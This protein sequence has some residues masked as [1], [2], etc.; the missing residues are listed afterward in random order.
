MSGTEEIINDA[1]EQPVETPNE[2]QVTEETNAEPSFEVEEGAGTGEH[3]PVQADL[4]TVKVDGEEQRV[5]LEELVRGYAHGTAANKRF[6]QAA[7]LRKEIEAEKEQFGQFFQQLQESPLQTLASIP[8]IKERLQEDIKGYLTEIVQLE[9]M[10]EE[11]RRA[12][13]LNRQ[14]AE[15]E[16]YFQELEMRKKQTEEEYQAAQ[17]KQQLG[18]W[19]AKEADAFS[20]SER[21]IFKVNLQAGLAQLNAQ[22]HVLTE[23][24]VKEIAKQTRELVAGFSPQTPKTVEVPPVPGKKG[25]PTG[26]DLV[27]KKKDKEPQKIE[28]F[29]SDLSKKYGLHY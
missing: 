14:I 11:E 9:Q 6:E 21:K 15:R 25:L 26:R 24:H 5:S 28:N 18:A 27:K 7:A 4:H 10:T 17:F 16:K 23:E 19:V 12:H 1:I 29:F 13:D 22:G 3:E 20:E 8:E 2:G